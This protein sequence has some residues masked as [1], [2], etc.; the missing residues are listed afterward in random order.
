MLGTFVRVIEP[1]TIETGLEALKMRFMA[2][3]IP[4]IRNNISLC[5]V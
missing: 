2:V 1:D 5:K 3:N 4:N